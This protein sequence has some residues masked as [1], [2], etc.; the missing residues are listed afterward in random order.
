M[1]FTLAWALGLIGVFAAGY[2]VTYLVV[3][4][5]SKIATMI[6]G[7]SLQRSVFIT[8]NEIDI[9]CV[10]GGIIVVVLV[11][12][13]W[14]DVGWEWSNTVG[15][16]LTVLGV[17]VGL[18]TF[19]LNDPKNHSR[20]ETKHTPTDTQTRQES[21]RARHKHQPEHQAGVYEV[22]RKQQ[23]PERARHKHQ[24]EHQARVY[25]IQRKQAEI[26]AIKD[27]LFSLF[28]ISD[29]RNQKRE[30]LLRDV[31]NRFFRANDIFVREAFELVIQE[32][33]GIVE[34]IEGIIEVD[35]YQY[36][37]EMKWRKEP[38]GTQEVSLHLVRLFNR[39]HPGGIFMSNSEFT[40]PA[41]TT[42]KEALSQKVVILCELEEIV[43]LLEQNGS[44]KDFLKAKITAAVVDKNPLFKPLSQPHKI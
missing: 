44:L 22:Q 24:T 31:L 28:G 40:Q 8:K 32:N 4:V 12:R 9:R 7:T 16:V 10:A 6:K 18:F 26:K 25:E 1:F 42:C 29:N 27:D 5:L 38:L 41:I 3:G 21:E 36:L 33:D 43:T 17:L 11:L 2:G 30:K 23:E 15:I 39:S 14:F 13:L 34:R 19:L 37:V 20:T 35:R